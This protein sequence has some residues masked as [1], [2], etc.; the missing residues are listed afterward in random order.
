M[1]LVP[2]RL[3]DPILWSMLTEV[4]PITLQLRFAV[5][6]AVMMLGFTENEGIDIGVG[7]LLPFSVILL[8]MITRVV[9]EI[10]LVEFDAESVYIVV[11]DGVMILDPMRL[12]APIPWSI[13]T[14]VAPITFQ[15]R[16]AVSPC[17]IIL[18]TAE[19]V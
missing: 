19:K 7:S 18:G 6:P 10:V 8:L 9:A 5:S 1:I 4:A 16:F 17:V 14:V 12:T 11:S 3:T 2:V 15:L 13:L